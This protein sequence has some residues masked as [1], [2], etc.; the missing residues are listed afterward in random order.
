MTYGVSNGQVIDDATWPT[1]VLWGSMVG[2]PSDSLA[3]CLLYTTL[4]HGMQRI[5]ESVFID[6]WGR[7]LAA[8]VTD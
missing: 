3:T 2:Y 8:H 6:Q 5:G 7:K 1:Q 4:Q